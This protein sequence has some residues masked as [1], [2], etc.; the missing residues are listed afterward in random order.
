MK[1]QKYY[2]CTTFWCGIEGQMVTL[3]SFLE[4]VFF[5]RMACCG[6][7]LYIFLVYSMRF[8]GALK[9][10][11]ISCFGIFPDCATHA[12]PGSEEEISTLAFFSCRFSPHSS[13]PFLSH[14]R[15]FVVWWWWWCFPE[16]AAAVPYLLETLFCNGSSWDLVFGSDSTDTLAWD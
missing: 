5:D 2:N 11:W 4:L 7:R 1:D 8:I 15:R 13:F 10:S 9:D 14:Y 3:R 6:Y 16:L 12:T